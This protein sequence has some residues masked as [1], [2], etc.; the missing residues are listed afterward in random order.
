MK[1]G[2]SG[3]EIRGLAKS[4]E[5]ESLKKLQIPRLIKCHDEHEYNTQLG[6]RG[7]QEHQPERENKKEEF[8]Q[9]Q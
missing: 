5:E 8:D 7:E 4:G 3:C 9:G 6:I 1:P 2:R